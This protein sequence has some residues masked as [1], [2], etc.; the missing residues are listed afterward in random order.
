MSSF[1]LHCIPHQEALCAKSLK[2]TH[3]RETTAKTVNFICES[4]L[5][6]PE[7]IE[8]LGEKEVNMVK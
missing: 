3:V 4:A 7:F 5:N 1:S 6:H 8:L 2:K